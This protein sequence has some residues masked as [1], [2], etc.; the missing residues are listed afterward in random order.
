MGQAALAVL[1][2]AQG[3]SELYAGAMLRPR[4]IRQGGRYQEHRQAQTQV[5]R[6]ADRTAQLRSL[7]SHRRPPCQAADGRCINENSLSEQHWGCPLIPVHGL[8]RAL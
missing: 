5:I 7:G 3:D 4:P 6:N 2:A 8:G 1:V